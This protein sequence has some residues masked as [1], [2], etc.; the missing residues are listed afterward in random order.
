[1]KRICPFL[2][3]L[4]L[5]TSLLAFPVGAEE[6]IAETQSQ[7]GAASDTTVDPDG[8]TDTDTNTGS[9]DDTGTSTDTDIDGDT[10]TDTTTGT[11][12]NTNEITSPVPECKH[13]WIYVE[14]DPTCTEYGAKGYYCS[15]CEGVTE[16]VAIDLAPHTYDHACD[17]SCNVCGNARETEH[18]FSTQWSKNSTK[19]WHACTVCGAKDGES[20]HYPGP[21]ATEEKAQYCLT[22]G[23]MM[24]A[25]KNHTHQY[26]AEYTG[27]KTGHWY[28]CATCEEKKDFASHVYDSLC[29]PDCNDCG[30][31]AD[32][33]HVFESGM[34]KDETGHWGV[35]GVCGEAAEKTAHTP[36]PAATDE[37]PQTCT[38]CGYELA[39][40][41]SHTHEAAGDWHC[42][43]DSHWKV[44]AC[45]EKMEAAAHSWDDGTE[46]ADSTV[47]YTCEDCTLTKIEGEPKEETAFPWI[48]AVMG[49][50]IVVMLACIV[51]LIFVIRSGRKQNG[52]FHRP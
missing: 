36:G 21:A 22:C 45:G 16:A 19:H 5:L 13:N 18:K 7:S 10:T 1:M 41:L 23:L 32:V 20:D 12:S 43:E 15:L 46:N 8:S 26:G 2:L 40:A 3:A 25:K 4:L 44:C 11:D 31:K 35:C 17:T 48:L 27:D 34:E 6:G 24:M 33:S 9:D 38:A 30:Y 49:V 51:A 47:T 42:D 14:V 28:A 29:D 50:L 39:P 52:K 37:V